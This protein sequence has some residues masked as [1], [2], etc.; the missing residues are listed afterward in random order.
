MSLDE[1]QQMEN[2]EIDLAQL[3]KSVWFYKFS[4]LVFI[5]FSVPIS[6]MYS[7]VLEPTYKAETVFEKPSDNNTQGSTALLNNIEGLGF[8]R[9]FRGISTVGSSDSFFSEL[10]SESF[11]KTVILNNSEIDSQKIKEFCPLP[12]KETARFS[13][14]S[15]LI[16]L[17]ISENRAPSESQKI[18]LLVRCV[19][20]MLEIDFDSYD[21]NESSAYRLSI[22][23][24]DPNFAANLANQ[25]VEKYFTLHEKKRDQSFRKVKEYLSKVITEAQIEYIEANNLLQQFKIKNTLLMNIRP[26]PDKGLNSS[27]SRLGISIQD[28]PFVPELNKEIANLSQLEK[29]LNQLKKASFNLS[30]LK[31]LNQ[32]KIKKFISSTDVQGVLSRKFITAISKMNNSSA[33]TSVINREIM[34]IV[35]QELITI[36]QQ[37][38]ILEEKIGKREEQ[39]MKLMSIENRF[40]ELAIDV[41]KKKLIFEGLKDQLK[42]KILTT[43]LANVEQPSLLTKAVPPFIKASPNKK[44]IVAL[45]VILSMFLGIAYILI[46]QISLKRIY[47]LSQLQRISGFLSCYSIK[48]KQLKQMDERSS[49]TVIGQSFFSHAMGMDKLGCIIDLSQKRKNH[50]LASEFSKTIANLLAADNS[51]I[52]CLDASP[53]KKS[54]SAST[55]KNF[56]L[57][58]GKLNVKGISGKNIISFN[59]EDGMIA[60]GEVNKIKSKYSKYDKIICALGTKIGDLTKFKFIE[61]CDFYILIGRSFGFDEQTYKKFSNTVW[62]KEKKCLGFFLID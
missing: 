50:L 59:D 54:F 8:L 48:Y 36:N 17:G 45:G 14:R 27:D 25:I 55:Q 12:R 11:L 39:T 2:D 38:Q 61:Q 31:E 43:G 44:L 26:I 23:S 5:V 42:E 7:S 41:A 15:I 9:A 49:E 19:N 24:K 10:R 3:F 28:S 57:D 32:E 20:Q 37:I 52:V 34:K 6:I 30:K 58:H 53:N 46:R 33:S 47:S 16:S 22:E 13:L 21:S 35:S 1:K 4:L 29:S 51:K 56:V 60:A 40:Q 62:E 18:S